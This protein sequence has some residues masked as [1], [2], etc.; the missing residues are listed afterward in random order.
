MF[1]LVVFARQNSLK[2]QYP[3]VASLSPQKDKRLGHALAELHAFL[4]SRKTKETNG[5]ID[6]FFSLELHSKPF[7]L[8]F[9]LTDVKCTLGVI[10]ILSHSSVEKKEVRSCSQRR[11]SRVEKQGEREREQRTWIEKLSVLIACSNF[12]SKFIFSRL[13]SSS[14]QASLAPSSFVK[15]PFSLSF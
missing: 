5:P 10:F 4:T 7:F 6:L 11:N 8:S 13:L 9:S 12:P 15:N 2:S 14:R 3:P 1:Q